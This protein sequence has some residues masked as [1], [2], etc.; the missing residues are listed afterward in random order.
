MPTITL[1]GRP[2]HYEDRGAGVPLLLFHGF[3]FTS[4]GFWPQLEAPPRGVRLIAPDHRGFG[5]SAAGPGVSTMEAMA[6]DGLAL[7]DA[8]ELPAALV[9]GVSMG[10][11]VSIALARLDPGRV[12][13]LLLIDTQSLPDDEAGRQ[14]R[15]ATAR[16][17]EQNGVGALVDGMLPRLFAAN[18]D[19]AVRARLERVMRAQ[20]PA[21]VAAASRGMGLRADGKDILSRFS[22][23]CAIVVGEHD[24]ITPV[25]RAKVM[26][27]LVEGSTLEVVPGAGHLVN[28]EQPAA[29]AAVVERLVASLP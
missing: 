2:Y 28:L 19:P 14:R 17:V 20:A 25:E 26:Q 6:E 7:L 22:G 21:A 3:P 13:G 27:G 24:V 9:G 11:Y 29:L 12:R 23:P 18:A 10:G 1:S 5:R 16:D 15:E 4:E 8:L